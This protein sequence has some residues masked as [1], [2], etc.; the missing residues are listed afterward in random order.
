[1][2]RIGVVGI[3]RIDNEGINANLKFICHLNRY[4]SIAN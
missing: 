1:M 3:V 2:K 4:A